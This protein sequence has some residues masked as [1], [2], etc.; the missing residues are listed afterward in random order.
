MYVMSQTYQIWT[1]E[2]IEHGEPSESGFAL[3]DIPYDDL[4]EL[5][6]SVETDANWAEW[7]SSQPRSGDWIESALETVDYRTGAQEIRHLFIETASGRELLPVEIQMITLWLNRDPL[8]DR[9]KDDEEAQEV[10]R[11][12]SGIPEE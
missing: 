11:I 3:Q 5:L 8:Y 6:D 10:W 4:F 1:P 9:Y 7:L 2:D 12:Y